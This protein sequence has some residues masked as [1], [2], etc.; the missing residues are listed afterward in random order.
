MTNIFAFVSQNNLIIMGKG[1]VKSKKGKLWRGSYGKRRP[2]KKKKS[3]V[4]R[5]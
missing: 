4:G 3:P 5:K 1:D 2:A